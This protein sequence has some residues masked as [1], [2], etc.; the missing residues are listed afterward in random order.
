MQLGHRESQRKSKVVSTD[1]DKSL[2]PCSHWTGL[3]H[4]EARSPCRGHFNFVNYFVKT[5]RIVQAASRSRGA[6]ISRQF[7]HADQIFSRKYFLCNQLIKSRGVAHLYLQP[8]VTV[9]VCKWVSLAVGMLCARGVR[10]F[11]QLTRYHGA[12]RLRISQSEVPLQLPPSTYL[13]TRLYCVLSQL[14]YFSFAMIF[15]SSLR[16]LEPCTDFCA[17]ATARGFGI[18]KP[19][20][21]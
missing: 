12:R 21:K 9:S 7:L 1:H 4:L 15:R 16:D 2:S 3:G 5:V 19:E 8:L 17:T 6:N 10:P 11:V 13:S 14:A 18:G 20:R